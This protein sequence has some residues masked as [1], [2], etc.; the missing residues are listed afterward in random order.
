MLSRRLVFVCFVLA[1]LPAC[2][3][4]WQTKKDDSKAKLIIVNV[5]DREQCDDCKIKGSICVPFMEV[6]K[7]AKGLDKN[8]EVV[9]YCANKMCSSSGVAC[10]KL[11]SL[12]FYKA[13]AYEGGTAEWYQLGLPVE[14]GCTASYLSGKVGLEAADENK[15]LP[16]ITAQELREKI[17]KIWGW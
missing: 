5:L 9:F 7:F 14:G 12:G 2:T 8:T 17:E 1:I 3:S 6:D 11:L 15:E 13:K 10:K 16:V 4:F